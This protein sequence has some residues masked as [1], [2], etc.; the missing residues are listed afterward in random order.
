MEREISE[1]LLL[2]FGL[3]FSC[4]SA[5]KV[6]FDNQPTGKLKW[7]RQVMGKKIHTPIKNQG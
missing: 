2:G 6:I 7:K 5:K 4:S 1:F 3:F